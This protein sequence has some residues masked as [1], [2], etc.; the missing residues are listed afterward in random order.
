MKRQSQTNLITALYCRLSRDDELQGES[1]SII[2]QKE[3]LQK[4]ATEHGFSNLQFYVDDGYSGTN[5]NR[6]DWKRLISQAENGEIGTIIVKDMSRLGRNYI[7]VGTYTEIMFPNLDIRFIAINNGVDSENGQDSD[8]TPFLNII[9]EWYAKDTSKKIKSVLKTK[10]D[11]GKHLSNK[12]CYGY[13]KDP[14]DPTKWIIDEEAASVVR[15]IFSLYMDGN[16]YSKIAKTLTED[17]VLNPTAYALSKG[18][19]IVTKVG[20]GGEYYWYSTTISK[21]LSCKE[22]IG[23]TVNFK[24]YQKS[25]K[26]RRRLKNDPMNWI[27]FEGT[28]DPIIERE[29]FDTVQQLRSGKH[30]VSE[31]MNEPAILSGLVYCPDCGKR[32]YLHRNRKL[33]P[34]LYSYNCSTFSKYGRAKCCSHFIR[35]KALEDLVLSNIKEVASFVESYEDQFLQIVSKDVLSRTSRSLASDRKELSAAL[36]RTAKLDQI[37]QRLY[38]DNLEG[39]ITD[40]RFLKLSANYEAEQKA[41]EERIPE[42]QKSIEKS[43]SC[44]TNTGQFL[45]LIHKYTD[46]EELSPRMV[47]ELISKV[48]VYRPE[49]INGKKRQQVVIEYNFVGSIVLPSKSKRKMA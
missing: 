27:V 30:R 16:G 29:V 42:L 21:M 23:C 18:I 35:M 2:H 28:H 5:F 14:V 10:G 31:P 40:E 43:E 45:K 1:N 48:Y 41:L 39:K 22:Y 8:F 11:S 13:I 25:F 49:K 37:I 3:M 20:E 15:R 33:S 7:E 6:P 26:Q 12:P 38:E 17:R 46:V 36:E 9:N 47:R 44:S 24:T 32:L 34:K 19:P 4:Y